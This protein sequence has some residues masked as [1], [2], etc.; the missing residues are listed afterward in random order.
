MPETAPESTTIHG[1]AAPS[2]IEDVWERLRPPSS[3]M[4][5][6][7]GGL[8]FLAVLGSIVGVLV[9]PPVVRPLIGSVCLLVLGFAAFIWVRGPA[10]RRT[11]RRSTA[12]GAGPALVSYAVLKLRLDPSMESAADFAA[13]SVGGHLGASLASHRKA[14]ATGREALADFAADWAD[15]DPSMQ[16]AVSL[17]GVAVETPSADRPAV[18]DRA[19]NTVLE[20]AKERVTAFA[21]DTRGPVMG[22]YAFGVMLPLALVGMLPVVSTTGGGVPLVLLALGYDFV[23]PVGLIAAGSWLAVKRPAVAARSGRPGLFEETTPSN[24]LV[25]GLAAGISGLVLGSL[26]LPDWSRWLLA[27]GTGIGSFLLVLL[28]PL[29][30]RLETI[31]AVEA[32]LPDALAV[33]GQSLAEGTPIE[34]AVPAVGDRAPGEIGSL[35]ARAGRRHRR[36]GV[37][38]DEAFRGDL[39]VLRDVPSDRIATAVSLVTAAAR[40]GPAGGRTLRSVAEYFDSLQRV[41]RESRREL[42]R[43]TSTLR[44]TAIVFA[45]AIAGVTVALATGMDSVDAPGDPVQVAMLG[46]II[47]WYVIALAVVLPSLSVVVERGFA[48]IRMGYRSAIALVTGVLVYPLTFVAARSLVYA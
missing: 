4:A 5:I 15:L 48:P 9:G 17:L 34:R 44:Q 47:G 21:A 27:F 8:A 13:D 41:E 6:A 19:L 30:E 46:R 18:L 28:S 3:S 10:L 45:P 14:A 11:Y 40:H 1:S 12:I 35:F 25:T 32:G 33:V 31:E 24:A 7:A 43:T 2:G 36:L 29:R 22:I 38:I 16:R 39:G 26:V 42:A 23:I 20:G 37:S